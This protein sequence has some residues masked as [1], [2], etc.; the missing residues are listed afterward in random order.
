MKI[1]DVTKFGDSEEILENIRNIALRVSEIAKAIRTQKT[2]NEKNLVIY[3]L[4]KGTIVECEKFLSDASSIENVA[5]VTRNTLEIYLIFRHICASNKNLR[6]WVGQSAKDLMDI[7]DGFIGL[8]EGDDINQY[9]AILKKE[10]KRIMEASMKHK[11]KHAGPFNIKDLSL[12]Y[13]LGKDYDALYKLCSKLVH[14]SSSKINSKEALVGDGSYLN[15]LIIHFQVYAIYI[16][17]D[18]EAELRKMA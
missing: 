10:K 15:I 4:L 3:N 5:L 18:A 1:K 6:K 17:N 12:K 13:D 7:L 14:P 8:S 16:I 9:R 11:V 2:R